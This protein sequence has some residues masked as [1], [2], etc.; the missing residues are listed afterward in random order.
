MS[1]SGAE[2]AGASFPFTTSACRQLM[3]GTG[4]GRG[5]PAIYVTFICW[6]QTRS[7]KNPPPCSRPH[8][9][10]YRSGCIY[11]FMLCP[12]PEALRGSPQAVR[13]ARTGQT[14]FRGVYCAFPNTYESF[15]SF[16][17]HQLAKQ[18]ASV[19]AKLFGFY[20]GQSVPERKHVTDSSEL[21]PTQNCPQSSSTASSAWVLSSVA[22]AA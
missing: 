9:G 5:L 7:L 8:N 1:V 4:G 11:L 15:Q 2:S 21:P 10:Y 12:R 20:L 13:D 19:G 18:A 22:S 17:G 14:M 3:P 16:W 6:S